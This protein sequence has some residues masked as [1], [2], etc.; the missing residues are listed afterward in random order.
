PQQRLLLELSW[1][2]M[3]D[4]GVAPEALAGSQA[5]VFIG[6]STQDYGLIQATEGDRCGTDAYTNSG[7]AACIAANRISFCF[8]LRG[9]SVAAD[10]ACSSWLV[11]LTLAAESLWAGR[12][13]VAL[14][15]GVNM[16]LRPECT[17]GFARA[18]MLSPAGR[19][20]SFDA[21]ADGYVRSEGAGVVVLKPLSEALSARDLIYAVVQ[22]AAV[23]QNGRGS[24]MT[25]PSAAAQGELLRDVY[26]EAGIAPE[27]VDFV[28]AHGTG[29]RVGDPIEA[30][31][32]GSVLGRTRG[33]GRECRIG[34]VKG[35]I[36]HLEA[37][38]GIAGLIKAA[39]SLHKRQIP[40]N[41][42]FDAPN[43]EIA[44]DAFHFRVPKTLED[45]PE[46][47]ET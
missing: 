35:N 36:G 15:G 29:T 26:R 11:A 7:A 23:N 37:A 17:L 30:A 38:A 24:G 33:R 10:T 27:H 25:V 31:A 47:E 18:S 32:L 43:P 1:E 22:G 28:E 9:P 19:C 12:C 4:A 14:A 42:H 8:D 6:I 39:L 45:W 2:A 21:G 20:R 3:E 41:L 13:S 46:P 40:P 16:L 44:F 34:S 5:G